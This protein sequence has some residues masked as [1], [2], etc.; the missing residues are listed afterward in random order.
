MFPLR[1]TLTLRDIFMEYAE[2][3]GFWMGDSAPDWGDASEEERASSGFWCDDYGYADPDDETSKN[4]SL[5]R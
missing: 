1:Q 3:K 5:W 2:N 4:V